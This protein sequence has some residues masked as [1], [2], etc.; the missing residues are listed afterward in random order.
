MRQLQNLS[1]ALL[2]LATLTVAATGCDWLHLPYGY[3]SQPA[4]ID[5]PLSGA[6]AEELVHLDPAVPLLVARAGSQVVAIPFD[7]DPAI[8]STVL[9]KLI[10]KGDVQGCTRQGAVA[11]CDPVSGVFVLNSVAGWVRMGERCQDNPERAASAGT[12]GPAGVYGTDEA[13]VEFIPVSLALSG[14][15][16]KRYGV[17]YRFMQ[18][19]MSDGTARALVNQSFDQS[20]TYL[21]NEFSTALFEHQSKSDRLITLVSHR[22]LTPSG[23]CVG[24]ISWCHKKLSRRC[25]TL[26]DHWYYK[27]IVTAQWCEMP[28]ECGPC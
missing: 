5:E 4:K 28:T 15:L 10:V 18:L 6:M 3:S 26:W 14:E 8:A 24:T 13:G 16:S 2:L 22:K 21:P 1:F 7:P 27:D 17:D 20:Q 25:R 12:G 9:D 11:C 23:G 19:A